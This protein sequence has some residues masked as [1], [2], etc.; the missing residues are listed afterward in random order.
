[1]QVHLRGASPAAC[2]G[3]VCGGRA[4][5]GVSFTNWVRKGHCKREK[6][7]ACVGRSPAGT[8]FPAA[9]I[10]CRLGRAGCGQALLRL[11]GSRGEVQGA[12]RC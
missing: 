5:V 1:M 4:R 8:V 12:P 11:P 6:L 3:G 7:V 2:A 9:S 10:A